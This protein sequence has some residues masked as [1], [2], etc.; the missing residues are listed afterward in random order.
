MGLS[1]PQEGLR[2]RRSARAPESL[3]LYNNSWITSAV[4]S[5]QLYTCDSYSCT[6]IATTYAVSRHIS[7]LYLISEAA[8]RQ[9]LFFLL[10]FFQPWTAWRCSSITSLSSDSCSESTLGRDSRSACARGNKEYA[11]VCW[12]ML[13]YADDVH[14][15]KTWQ[16]CVRISR[17][18]STANT[19]RMCT[20]RPTPWHQWY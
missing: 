4:A 13:T 11:D 10:S 12:H 20:S 18:R 5:L 6:T 19:R 9:S 2:F 17:T 1:E 14:A 8:N 16:R 7:R 3:Q 15:H